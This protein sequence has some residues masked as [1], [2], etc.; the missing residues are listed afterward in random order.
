M[1]RLV[2]YDA[3]PNTS[4]VECIASFTRK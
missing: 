4:H 3:F 1:D 2:G